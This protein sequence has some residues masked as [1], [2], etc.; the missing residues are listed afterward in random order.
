[1]SLLLE[2]LLSTLL[3]SGIE[4]RLYLAQSPAPVV[5]T[6]SDGA[7]LHNRFDEPDGAGGVRSTLVVYVPCGGVVT[8]G[9]TRVE[10]WCVWLPGVRG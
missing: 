7:V 4:Q 2:L 5:V 8:I 1:M 6:A 9:D 10:R 3:A